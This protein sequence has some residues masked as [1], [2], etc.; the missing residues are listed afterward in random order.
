MKLSLTL[1]VGLSL[2]C[3]ALGPK[4]EVAIVKGELTDVRPPKI[5]AIFIPH[6]SGVPGDAS[7]SILVGTVSTYLPPQG[8]SAESINILLDSIGLPSTIGGVMFTPYQAEFVNAL[9]AHREALKH[10]PKAEPPRSIKLPQLY[11][12]IPRS[13]RQAKAI[14][15]SLLHKDREVRLLDQ[16]LDSGD[17]A[18]INHALAQTHQLT[19]PLN[20]LS[21]FFMQTTSATYI[22]L[23]HVDGTK[24]DWAAGKSITVSTAMVNIKTGR[25]RYFATVKDKAGTIPI[26]YTAQLGI[27]AASLFGGANDQAPVSMQLKI[28][29][30]PGQRA[31]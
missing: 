23:T 18:K 20:T 31:Y 10:N 19:K 2:S 25:F 4:P 15:K 5:G 11:A 28:W 12:P 6:A 22:L 17:P 24:K 9:H 14:G 30:A 26:P 21:R 29:K 27:M 1:L 3:A 16:A 7:S 13:T 8:I